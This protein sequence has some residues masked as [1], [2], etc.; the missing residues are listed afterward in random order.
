MKHKIPEQ[1]TLMLNI[2]GD[3]AYR[4]AK[5]LETIILPKVSFDPDPLTMA[6]EATRLQAEAGV[7]LVEIWAEFLYNRP[8]TAGGYDEFDGFVQFQ[9]ITTDLLER[10]R[11]KHGG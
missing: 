1:N 4:M 5:L 3:L 6:T 2:R 11:A 10:Y 8:A 9:Q 7:A